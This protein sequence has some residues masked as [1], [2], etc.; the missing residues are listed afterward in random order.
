MM[1]CT[2]DISSDEYILAELEIN[3]RSTASAIPLVEDLEVI[4]QQLEENGEF[5]DNISTKIQNKLAKA[6]YWLELDKANKAIK[7]LDNLIDYITKKVNKGKISAATGDMLLGLIE[8]II[9]EISV[10]DNDGDG[11]SAD[12]DCD[13]NNASINPDNTTGLT[14]YDAI[15]FETIM[16][17]TLNSEPINADDND[18]N[19][20]TPGAIVLYKTNQGRFGK[21]L[22]VEYGYN[23]TVQY[24]TYNYDGTIRTSSPDLVIQ[25]TFAVDFDLG[26][27]E[28]FDSN[29]IFW[30]Q[31]T[32][33][34]RQLT[35]LD[36]SSIA[37]F[38][39]E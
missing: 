22:I 35:P 3:K 21:L 38:I 28:P 6:K 37:L 13:D 1:S 29:D 24:L 17:Q 8:E 32:E 36:N 15:T 23:L 11:Y 10:L 5:S 33:I 27:S 19:L 16:D 20:L 26:T 4:V 18:S 34:E 12:E 39:C 30:E 31:E 9:D 7:K 25:G 2:K 14:V